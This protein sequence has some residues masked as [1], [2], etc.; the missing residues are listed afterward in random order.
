[1]CVVFSTK[2]IIWNLDELVLS[3]MEGGRSAFRLTHRFFFFFFFPEIL[4]KLLGEK[5]FVKLKEKKNPSFE[6][7]YFLCKKKK[8]KYFIKI[9]RAE[10][11]PLNYIETDHIK[12]C[13]FSS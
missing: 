11:W 13:V 2:L 9:I 6:I 5:E 10:H 3:K 4:F 7:C 12:I 1:M 8:D